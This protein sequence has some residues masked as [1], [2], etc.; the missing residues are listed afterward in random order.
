METVVSTKGQVVIP[1][2]IASLTE[3]QYQCGRIYAA[4]SS[5]IPKETTAIVL[6]TS[7]KVENGREN[8]HFKI[9]MDAAART[10]STSDR[11]G[12]AA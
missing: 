5:G 1:E 4:N 3:F 11:E 10:A 9:R 12:S 7:K 6:G 8:L 2:A